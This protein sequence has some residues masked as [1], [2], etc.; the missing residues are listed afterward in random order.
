MDLRATFRRADPRCAYGF[1]SP[2]PLRDR[3]RRRI[4]DVVLYD[5]RLRAGFFWEVR[6]SATRFAHAH[7]SSWI[8][9]VPLIGLAIPLAGAGLVHAF[10]GYAGQV[11]PHRGHPEWRET[12]WVG[13]VAAGSSLAG[14]LAGGV[15]YLG[16]LMA[17]ERLAATFAPVRRLLQNKYYVDEFYWAAFVRPT[18][19][20]ARG[21]AWFD[22]NVIDRFLWT[23]SAGSLSSG[24]RRKA[25]WTI[26]SWT[27]WWTEAAGGPRAWAR[28]R[29]RCRTDLCRITF[30]GSPWPSWHF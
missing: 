4:P 15:L 3:L 18:A 27:A 5:A 13:W 14:L 21:I 17:V 26:T 1:E 2:L 22:L 29:A 19:A 20:L 7:E 6:A 8:M 24:L 23:G 9:T 10:A 11:F 28:W 12:A 30:C 16:P 25:G